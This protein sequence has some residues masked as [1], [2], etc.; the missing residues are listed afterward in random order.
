[1]VVL[2]ELND[3]RQREKW[4]EIKEKIEEHFNSNQQDDPYILRAYTQALEKLN[5]KN[6]IY[7]GAL[8]RMLELKDRLSDTALRLAKYYL[9]NNEKEQA[10]RHYE[11]ALEAAINERHYDQV[12]TIWMEL[13]EIAPKNLI[14]YHQMAQ[15][16]AEH[17]H[18]QRAAMLLQMLLPVYETPGYA[19]QH[20]NLLKTIIHYTPEDN[21]L[22]EPLIEC[23]R[24]LHP[25]NSHIEDII[26]ETKATGDRPLLELVQELEIFSRFMP[27][28]Y[29]RHPDW[30][31]GRVKELDTNNKR[32]MINFQRKRNHKMDLELAAHAVENLADDDFRVLKVVN[33]DRINQ[34]IEEEPIEL[35]KLMLRSFGGS[36]T[37]KEIKELLVPH[38]LPSR[39]WSSWWSSTNSSLR[40]DSYI[41]VSSGSNKRYTLREEAASDEDELTAR[42]DRTRAPH[43]KVDLIY[44]Y[45]RTTKREELH[46]HVIQHF[47]KKIHSLAPRRPSL[48]E[49][50]EL[51]FTNEDLKS[52]CQEIQ[53]LP[54]DI[55]IET[56]K[57]PDKAERNLQN[58]RFK[59]HQMRYAERLK[60]FHPELW[61]KEFRDLLLEPNVMVRDGLAEHLV[62]EEH[63]PYLH[64]VID[65]TLNDFRKYPHTFIWFAGIHLQGKVNWLEE[66]ISKIVVIERLLLLVDFLTSQAKRREK[67]EASWLR[68]V[69]ADAREIIRKGRYQYI[70]ENLDDANETLAQSIYRRAQA[71]EGLD[72]STSIDLTTIIRAKFPTLFQQST[73]EESSLP[74]GLYC[75]KESLEEKKILLKRLVEEELPA[76]VREI[77]TAR[78]H[79]DL[80]ENAEY[81]AAKDKQKLLA[82][83]TAELQEQLQTAQAL[84][85]ANIETDRVGFGT[86]IKLSPTGSDT[87]EEYIILGPWESDPDNN[88]HSYQAPFARSFMG[89]QVGDI[90]DVE[91]PMHT[92]KYE[93]ASIEPI[94]QDIINKVIERMKKED[95]IIEPIYSEVSG[96]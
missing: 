37:A 4:Q 23:V 48:A 94:P 60:E 88:I 9:E 67:D 36:L 96:G 42:F 32:V 52:Y 71:N 85:P 53:S 65:I 69:A 56:L 66:K 29:V 22:R 84:D 78:G 63:E 93:I 92:G 38:C 41:S 54:E 81:H 58:L 59:T 51:W 11:I 45:L 62:K 6:E 19:E 34:M 50:A 28:N 68:S 1:M 35:I 73:Q 33:R 77:E 87:L 89:K 7:E 46:D 61:A 27:D 15:K 16:L 74:E 40:K 95:E 86:L 64:E 25:D 75:L 10:I 44:E 39:K 49:R 14:F 26:K 24:E 82:S 12:D 13:I 80:R 43:A 57:D 55:L 76:V 83:Q 30:G 21:N 70:K 72:Q 18:H 31:V 91:L 79:G 20:F 17:H 5:E 90:V 3:L 47:S 8:N 2:E